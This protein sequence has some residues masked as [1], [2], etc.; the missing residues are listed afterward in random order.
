MLY[1][2]AH[3]LKLNFP[4][5]WGWIDLINGF[6]FSIRYGG[7]LKVIPNLLENRN[8][9][10]SISAID[11]IPTAELVAFFS[12]Q[13]KEAFCYFKPHGFDAGS[14]S[15]LQ[16]N[17]SFL[18]FVFKDGGSIAGYCFLR[19]FFHGKA[20]RGRMVG[21]DYRGRGLGTFMNKFMNEVGFS[22]GLRIFETVSKDNVASYRSSLA[23]SDVK[24]IKV[25]P[26]N[27]LFLE[28]LPPKK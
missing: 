28:I 21:I 6:L 14:I 10:Y 12:K 5:L 16:K 9:N 18:A 2:L 20:F 7:V 23:A 3:F 25:L 11:S 15:K 1:K 13:P 22:L 4:F 19:S 8:S 24:I 26:N 17:K 27:E